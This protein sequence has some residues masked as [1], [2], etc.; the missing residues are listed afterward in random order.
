LMELE[1]RR[2]QHGDER[3]VPRVCFD[4]L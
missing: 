3:G 2:T 1:E 4:F